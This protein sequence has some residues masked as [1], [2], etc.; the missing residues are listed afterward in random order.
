MKARLSD[1]ELAQHWGVEVSTV[2]S[3]RLNGDGPAHITIGKNT[4]RY[5]MEDIELYERSRVTG[6]YVPPQ[7]ISA[8]H[9]AA[10][11]FESVATWKI[12]DKTRGHLLDMA[13][14]MRKLANAPH[15]A[16]DSVDIADSPGNNAI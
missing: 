16:K 3:W 7:A 2:R 11:L 14:L 9:G 10:A 4:V 13:A 1:L 5:R 8:M 15:R 6:G 12:R